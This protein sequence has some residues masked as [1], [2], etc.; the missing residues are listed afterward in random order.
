MQAYIEANWDPECLE[1][2]KPFIMKCLHMAWMMVVQS[3]PMTFKTCEAD[4]RFDKSMF[5][6]Y[7][8]RGSYVDFMVWP[9]LLLEKDGQV[10]AKG[11]AQG[12]EN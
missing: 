3:P 11:I 8:K 4:E 12:K 10:V 6:E 7:T 1:V 9:V 5:K 2:L